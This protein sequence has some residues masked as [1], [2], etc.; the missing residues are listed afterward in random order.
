MTRNDKIAR[1]EIDV[2]R[3]AEALEAFETALQSFITAKETLVSVLRE[4]YA[5]SR[6]HKGRM[7]IKAIAEGTGHCVNWLHEVLNGRREPQLPDAII[8]LAKHFSKKD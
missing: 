5:K 3:V 4:E 6:Y 2:E 1:S 7:A 8:R